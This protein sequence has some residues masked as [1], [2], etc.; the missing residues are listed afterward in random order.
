M[1]FFYP[2]RAGIVRGGNLQY[3]RRKA[4]KVSRQDEN[5]AEEGSPWKDPA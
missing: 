5:T 3:N 2:A 4:T 1:V